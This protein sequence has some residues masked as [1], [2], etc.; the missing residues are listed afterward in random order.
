MV[1]G[2]IS[3]GILWDDQKKLLH[4]VDIDEAEVHT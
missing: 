1:T 3:A 2:L 4:W